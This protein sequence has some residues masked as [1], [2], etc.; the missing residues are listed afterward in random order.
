MPVLAALGT[1]HTP[2]P[3]MVMG[4]IRFR[5]CLTPA[6]GCYI[7]SLMNISETERRFGRR[8]GD[9]APNEGARQP[10]GWLAP[11]EAEALIA[12]CSRRAP[13]G[14]RN[15]AMI[16]LLYR[17]GLRVSEMLGD[18]DPRRKIPPLR[19]SALNFSDRSIRLLG[20][21]SGHPQ[22]RY[23]H[24]WA[25]DALLRWLEERRRMGVARN[26]TPLFCTITENAAHGFHPGAPVSRQYL[27]QLLK[28]LAAEAG[29][30]KRVHPHGLRHTHAAELAAEGVPINVIS[31][32]LGHA[33]SGVTARYIDHLAPIDVMAMGRARRWQEPE[34][35]EPLA[36][37]AE[38]R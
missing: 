19:P 26:G 2:P 30:D 20:T 38:R 5:F 28:R 23:W 7:I 15:R 9:P 33:G 12:Q 4:A 18:K 8:P 35:R 31:K 6:E 29:I 13:S 3:V 17:S 11:A 37:N 27:T 36:G 24:A 10:A 21:K 32:Q 34:K 16:T 1:S 25:D 22:T 14:I